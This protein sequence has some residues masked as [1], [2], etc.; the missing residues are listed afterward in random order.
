MYPRS[1]LH[2]EITALLGYQFLS[3]FRWEGTASNYI[4]YDDTDPLLLRLS[5]EQLAYYLWWREEAREG[6]F[7]R[8]TNGYLWIYIYDTVLNTCYNDENQSLSALQE[9]YHS[10]NR[11][12]PEATHK[13]LSHQK[14]G[15]F[16]VNYA[17]YN[18]LTVDID[19]LFNTYGVDDTFN[20]LHRVAQGHFMGPNF[21]AR[22]MIDYVIRK[23]QI[24]CRLLFRGRAIKELVC[25]Y[26]TVKVQVD[27][28]INSLVQQYYPKWKQNPEPTITMMEVHYQPLSEDQI[29][30][31]ARYK[32]ARNKSNNKHINA[33]EKGKHFTW[34]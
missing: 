12:S 10:Y 9:L 20:I 30:I 11:L 31:P 33:Q 19:R 25:P 23:I 4:G 26:K 27:Q 8:T 34:K 2:R 28:I 16:I 21:T 18:G 15:F 24:S 7:H 32:Y 13:E 5:S 22:L 29:C 3:Y 17:L 6:I 1:S 14:L